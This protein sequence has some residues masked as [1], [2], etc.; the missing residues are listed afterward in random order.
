MASMS[1]GRNQ[2]THQPMRRYSTADTQRGRNTQ[3]ASQATPANATSHTKAHS[4]T[5]PESAS[6]IR[7]NGV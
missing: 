6:E 1:A 2:M 4:H 5:P 3:N 7:Q